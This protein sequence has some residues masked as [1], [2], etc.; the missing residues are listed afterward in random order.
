MTKLLFAAMAVF[1]FGFTNAQEEM[2]AYG[3][4]SGD[5]IIE[6]NVRFGSTNDKNSETKSSSFNFAP[7]AGYFLSEDLVVGVKLGIGSTKVTVVGTT[8]S[9]YSNVGAGVFG[10]YYFLDLGERFKT[11]SELNVGFNSN[12]DKISDIKYNIISSGVGLGMNYFVKKNIA[13][14]F[15]LTDIISY[16]TEKSDVSGAKSV[17]SLNGNVNVFNNFFTTAQFGLMFKL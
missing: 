3:F 16:G 2:S 15:G 17:N 8:T 7:K 9:E 14:S 4:S 13:I 10:R 11:Y 12:K 1:A 6:G 5:I